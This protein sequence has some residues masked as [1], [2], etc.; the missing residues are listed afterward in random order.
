[1]SSSSVRVSYIH[2]KPK[3]VFLHFEKDSINRYE[4]LKLNCLNIYKTLQTR[5][6]YYFHEREVT[7]HCYM[8]T[9]FTLTQ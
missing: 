5:I 9:Y 6:V 4:H 2:R 3:L 7:F 8:K 1:M